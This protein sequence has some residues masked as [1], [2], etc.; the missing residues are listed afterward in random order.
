[1]NTNRL[2]NEELCAE[3]P[4]VYSEGKFELFIKI[5]EELLSRLNNQQAMLEALRTVPHPCDFDSTEGLY[6]ALKVWRQ[7]VAKLLIMKTT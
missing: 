4:L 7:K 2:T 6:V 3:L 5:K 1:M